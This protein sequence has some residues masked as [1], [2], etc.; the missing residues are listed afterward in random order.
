EIA[1]QRIGEEQPLV[2]MLVEVDRVDPV[3]LPRGFVDLVEVA[4]HDAG[5]RF[6]FGFRASAARSTLIFFDARFAVVTDEFDVFEA[7]FL[8][9][10]GEVNDRGKAGPVADEEAAL[11]VENVS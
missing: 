5:P 11:A 7:K 1:D 2:V 3:I 6:E 8:P 9:Q 10:F 4:L